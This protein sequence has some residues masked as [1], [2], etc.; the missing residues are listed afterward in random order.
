MLWPPEKHPHFSFQHIWKYVLTTPS[1]QHLNHM[2]STLIIQ[3]MILEWLN[4][5]K[6][7]KPK[8]PKLQD[9]PT[10]QPTFDYGRGQ[11]VRYAFLSE[12]P[13]PLG[14]HKSI[15]SLSP[16]SYRV[17]KRPCLFSSCFRLWDEEQC[18]QING[19]GHLYVLNAHTSKFQES[20]FVFQIY[21]NSKEHKGSTYGIRVIGFVPKEYYLNMALMVKIYY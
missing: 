12:T 4:R 6:G 8:L 13:P 17:H 16:G 15:S 20:I 10:E 11:K 19:A 1:K 14:I 7:H 3:P 18:H 21:I 9:I 2:V 5:P